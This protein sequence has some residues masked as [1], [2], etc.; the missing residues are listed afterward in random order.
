MINVAF[1]VFFLHFLRQEY[2]TFQLAASEISKDPGMLNRLGVYFNVTMKE[3]LYVVPVLAVIGLVVLTF[4]KVRSLRWANYVLFTG[5]LLYVL[6]FHKL[7]NLDMRPL[8]LGVQARF[9]QQVT[10]SCFLMMMRS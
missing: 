1:P 7:A 3:T 2:G 4:S 9:W 5:Y 8:F 10:S 6:V